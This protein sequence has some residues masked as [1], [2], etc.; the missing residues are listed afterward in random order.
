MLVSTGLFLPLSDGQKSSTPPRPL[1]EN[2]RLGGSPG[3]LRLSLAPWRDGPVAHG[4]P[5]R[6][7]A[8]AAGCPARWGIFRRSQAVLGDLCDVALNW[9]NLGHCR[10]ELQG[11]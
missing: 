9:L 2:G 7:L 11:S 8:A 4:Q 6:S 5:G 3:I 10:Q 1:H